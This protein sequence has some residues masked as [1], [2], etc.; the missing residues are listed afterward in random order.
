MRRRRFELVIGQTLYST[1]D[2]K[3]FIHVKQYEENEVYDSKPSS[4]QPQ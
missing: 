3:I 4:S 1:V 2:L